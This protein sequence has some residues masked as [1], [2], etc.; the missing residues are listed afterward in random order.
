MGLMSAV[1]T[2]GYRLLKTDDMFV[3][4]RMVGGPVSFWDDDDRTL[5]TVD[6]AEHRDVLVDQVVHHPCEEWDVVE[7]D[8][9]VFE[10]ARVAC[11]AV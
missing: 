10:P 11:S 9:T 4:S 7:G 1:R 5:A 8:A 6:A 3:G 2:P